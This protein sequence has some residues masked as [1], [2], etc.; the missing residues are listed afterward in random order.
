ANLFGANLFGADL[1]RANLFGANL[2]GA[3]LYGANLYGATWQGLRID[4]L[5]SGQVTL[6]PTPVGWSLTVGCWKGNT[7]AG[8][9]DI[10]D[11]KATP[12]GARG[13]EI[14]RRRPGWIAVADLCDAH[15]AAH[16]EAISALADKWGVTK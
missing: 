14:T 1:C 3:N 10:I 9:R 11:G 13:D 15:I 12:P 16:P 7:V 5:P 8:L 6:A 2:F 4:G